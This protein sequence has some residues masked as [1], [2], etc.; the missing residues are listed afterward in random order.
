MKQRS[1]KALFKKV[2]P[3]LKTK[4]SYLRDFGMDYIHEED[5]WNYLI[6]K[7]WDEKE[8]TIDEIASDILNLPGYLVK[9]YLLENNRSK[10]SNY[11]NDIL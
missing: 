6:E 5:I 7:E 11:S 2:L 8:R 9:D 3:I 1:N 10:K 4:V